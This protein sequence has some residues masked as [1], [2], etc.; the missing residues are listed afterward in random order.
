MDEITE[1]KRLRWQCR[2]GMKEMDALL[3]AWLDRGWPGADARTRE[4]FHSLLAVEDDVLWAWL[5]GRRRPETDELAAMVDAIH[6]L[7]P[8]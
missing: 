3:L 1:L 7:G 6:A 5:S 2:R 4:V 8:A